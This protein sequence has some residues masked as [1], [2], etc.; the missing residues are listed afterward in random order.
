M[1]TSM[2]VKRS[3]LVENNKKLA[4][5]RHQKL[6][7]VSIPIQTSARKMEWFGPWQLFWQFLPMIFCQWLVHSKRFCDLW[8][9]RPKIKE[10]N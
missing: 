4:R 2:R 7:I 6:I 5:K 10:N 8:Y 3:G 9:K 1:K